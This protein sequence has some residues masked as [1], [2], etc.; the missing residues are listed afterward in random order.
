MV[1][2]GVWG[3]Y[4]K[5]F[6]LEGVRADTVAQTLGMPRSRHLESCGGRRQTPRTPQFSINKAGC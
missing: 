1:L 2:R 3:E 5:R 4:I 6:N